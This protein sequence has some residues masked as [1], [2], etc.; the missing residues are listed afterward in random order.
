MNSS[1]LCFS[2]KTKKG[3][4]KSYFE[5]RQH[6]NPSGKT[7]EIGIAG[8]APG[9]TQLQIDFL[10]VLRITTFRFR[11]Q[12]FFYWKMNLVIGRRFLK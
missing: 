4:L 7:I 9:P 2:S 10:K 12:S 8:D 5:C 11:N 3:L 6:F 1:G